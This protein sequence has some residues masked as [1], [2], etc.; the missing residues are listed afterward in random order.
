MPSYTL[1]YFN[2]RGRARSAVCCSQLLVSSTMTAERIFRMG[3]HEKQ[4]AMSHDAN[5]GIGQQNSNSP[6]YAMARYL[7]RE[8]GFHGRNNMEMARIDF[9]S[10]CFYDILDDYM[11]M[12]QDGNCRMMFQRS[13]DMSSSSEKRM[14]FQE[15]C[16]RILPFMERTLEMYSGGSQYFMGDQMTMADMMCYCALENPLMEEPSMLSSYPKLMALRN[17]VM[18]HSKMSSYLQRRSRTEF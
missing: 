2:H 5:V 14:R 3:Q 15:T 1:H 7:A 13:R 6:E 17:R 11:R 4:D 18:N 10:D 9:I 12:Y 8:F 16:R